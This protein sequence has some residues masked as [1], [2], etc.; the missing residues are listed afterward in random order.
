MSLGQ[1]SHL[2]LASHFA[3]SNLLT[4]NTLTNQPSVTS[5]LL[6]DLL[7]SQLPGWGWKGPSVFWWSDGHECSGRRDSL[8]SGWQGHMLGSLCQ[9]WEQNIVPHSEQCACPALP[10]LDVMAHMP[11]TAALGR[12]G[13]LE[14]QVPS[15]IASLRPT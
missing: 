15:Y 1:P 8:G 3:G 11:V 10:R 12:W 13:Q 14:I 2:A 6:K 7:A 4:P 9:P 5:P